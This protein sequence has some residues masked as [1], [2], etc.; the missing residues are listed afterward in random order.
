M[1]EGNGKVFN[2]PTYIMFEKGVLGVCISICFV[3]VALSQLPGDVVRYV[4]RMEYF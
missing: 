2:S 1:S 3:E 4:Y